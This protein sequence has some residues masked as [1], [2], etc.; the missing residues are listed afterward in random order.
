MRIKD[1]FWKLTDKSSYIS[2]DNFLCGIEGADFTE[3]DQIRYTCEE[4]LPN[5]IEMAEAIETNTP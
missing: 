4:Y 1:F 3:L 2:H 5:V